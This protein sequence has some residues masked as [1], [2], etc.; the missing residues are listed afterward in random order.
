[1]GG[2]HVPGLEHGRAALELTPRGK[3]VQPAAV[4]S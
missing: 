1:V 3:A 2:A 4:L